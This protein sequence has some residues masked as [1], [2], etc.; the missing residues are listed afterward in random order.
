MKD[1]FDGRKKIEFP[2][3]VPLLH[4]PFNCDVDIERLS[5]NEKQQHGDD[6]VCCMFLFPDLSGI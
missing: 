2:I 1:K 5:L 6:T 4:L 3:L